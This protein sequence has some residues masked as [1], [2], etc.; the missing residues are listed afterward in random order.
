MSSTTLARA[1]SIMAA[2]TAVSRLLGFVRAAGLIAVVGLSIS[3]GDAFD[4]ANSAPNVIHA[5]VAGGVLNAVLV[6]QV[7]RAMARDTSGRQGGDYVDRLVTVAVLVMGVVTVAVAVGAPLVVDLFG[8]D[9]LSGPQR[10]LTLAFAYWCLPQVFFYALYTLL[11]Q[12]LN[13]R[14]SFGPYMWAPAVNNVV[15]LAGIAVFLLVYGGF[16]SGGP[17]DPDGADGG[18]AW[19]GAQVALLAGTATLGV[20]AQALVLLV[21]LRRLGLRLRPRF[22]LRGMGLRTAGI[23]AGWSFGIVAVGTLGFL[24]VSRIATGARME[25]DATSVSTPGLLAW[26][27]AFLIF[28]VPHS[29][30]AVSVVTALFTSL[31]TSAAAGRTREVVEATSTGLRTVGVVS[32]L[33]LVGMAVLP[34]PLLVLVSGSLPQSRAV[35]PVLVAMGASLVFFSALY[36][37]QRVFYAYEDARTPFLLQCVSVG[38]WLAGSGASAVLLGPS[39]RLVGVAASMSAGVAVAA[40]LALVLVRR[41][42][43]SVDG[44]A[45]LRTHVRLVLAGAV[46]AVVGVLVSRAVGGSAVD[47]RLEAAVALVVAGGAITVVYTVCLLV[48]R[49]QELEPL[50][51]RL[52]GASRR[53]TARH[54]VRR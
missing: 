34:V 52:P 9:D 29:L 7:V 42:L 1:S 35:A 21:P 51:A 47:G 38:V 12:I 26:S 37:L 11:G 24:V 53:S 27:T 36:L 5:V 48:L 18:L 14:G 2:G 13:A 54:R 17:G 33:G 41:R 50:R 4:L 16:A 44:A 30:V 20:V 39:Q 43:G 40:V 8:S 15:A 10:A 6:P 3:A 49:V 22:G 46:A 32:V 45:V 31:S 25:T 28:M 19:S 23:V